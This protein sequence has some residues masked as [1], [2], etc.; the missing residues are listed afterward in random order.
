MKKLLC[1]PLLLLLMMISVAAVA[2][3]PESAFAEQ[4]SV[5]LGRYLAEAPAGLG[6]PARDRTFWQEL[7]RNGGAARV[8]AAASAVGADFVPIPDSL[9]LAFFRNGNRT[10]YE[11]ELR[12]R[13]R[14]LVNLTLAECLEYRG[15]F[16]PR[17]EKQLL[18]WCAMKTWLL[19][20]HDH[21]QRNF[22][23]RQIDIDLASSQAGWEIATVL[24]LLGDK[25]SPAT[26]GRCRTELDRRIFQPFRAMVEGKRDRN[27]WLNG[28]NNWNAVC[29]TGVAGAV[30]PTVVSRDERLFYLRACL[31][32]SR[33]FLA[34]F[35]RDGYC[36]EGINYWAYGFGHYL[37]LA[38]MIRR[39]TGNHLNLMDDPATRAPAVYPENIRLTDSLYPSFADA[40][41]SGRISPFWLGLRDSLQHRPSTAW[42]G[43]GPDFGLALA[44]GM[45]AASLPRPSASAAVL[46]PAPLPERSYFPDG[47]VLVCRSGVNG[48]CRQAA[49][50]KGGSNHEMHNHND[51]GS[52]LLAVDG[53]PFAVDPGSEVYTARTF[54]KRRY[55]SKVIGS[56]GHPV[57][58]IDGVMQHDGAGT[59][60]P[61]LDAAFTP[62][63]DR[64]KINMAPAYRVPG[65]A[66]LTRTFVF[67]RYGNGKFAVTDQARFNRPV[68]FE[69][70]VIT[71][72]EW[73]QTSDRSFRLTAQ[74]KTVDV[75]V[76]AGTA[77]VEF[78]AAPLNEDMADRSRPVRIAIR[79]KEKIAAPRVTVTFT[80]GE[81]R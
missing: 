24:W 44:Q 41:M 38:E 25:L 65:M 19:P 10:G 6:T 62:A 67:S 33:N 54:G 2:V 66:M 61:I 5:E 77:A 64:F 53:I 3:T 75:N 55:E 72:G 28:N 78:A 81:S 48:T 70:A 63:L 71:V 8:I 30:L 12:F 7:A 40:R 11:K 17:L 16:L 15:R 80:A 42:R 50:M 46:A 22:T 52:Y 35:P 32:Y 31:R 23:G 26:V 51:V 4:A 47:G 45:L 68:T 79:L 74:G 43:I 39:A 34:G 60:A 58:L 69:T 73:R 57:P 49:A 20:A 13:H 36:S 56:Y 9:Y 21:G 29:L 59:D 14:D 37:M 27:W 18:G 76:D 1:V